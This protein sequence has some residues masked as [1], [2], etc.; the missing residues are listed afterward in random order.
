MKTLVIHPKDRSTDFLTPIYEN[1]PDKT[2]ITG[3]Y[4]AKMD[5]TEL[6][7]LIKTHDRVI[8]MGHGCPDGL[9]S[10]GLFKN[11]KGLVI[12]NQTT[13]LLMEKK[14]NVYIWCNAD[15]FVKPRNLKGFYSGMFISEVGEAWACN[16]KLE[17]RGWV[18]ESN[19]KFAEILSKY[20]NED[21]ET[22]KEKVTEEYGLLGETNLVA[23]YN[24]ERLFID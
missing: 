12:N 6:N 10:I 13:E 9:F 24:N 19:N 17:N 5:I 11:A 20:V 21:S 16:V 2:V 23:R 14:D 4:P 8:M 15:R 3:E 1:I 22:I 18:R 7:E